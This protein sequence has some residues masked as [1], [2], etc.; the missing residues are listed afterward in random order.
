M[1]WLQE[2]LSRSQLTCTV[3]KW[4][5]I[6]T[7]SLI[8]W[9]ICYV[10][11]CHVTWMAKLIA[12]PIATIGTELVFWSDCS[13]LIDGWGANQNKLIQN[14]TNNCNF[15]QFRLMHQNTLFTALGM[16]SYRNIA[17]RSSVLIGPYIDQAGHCATL[18][19]CHWNMKTFPNGNLQSV[20]VM[21]AKDESLQG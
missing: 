14:T 5:Q 7:K 20:L 17:L 19:S 12:I 18:V 10:K 8:Y 1:F 13:V 6:K 21:N 9:C 11:L 4:F 3:G 15:I 2:S 16:S